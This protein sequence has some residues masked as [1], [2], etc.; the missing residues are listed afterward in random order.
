MRVRSILLT[1]VFGLLVFS[2]SQ[3]EKKDTLFREVSSDKSNITFANKL[4]F[5]DEFNIYTY[6]NYYNGGGAAVG[7]VNNDGLVDIYL[8]ANM[9]GNKLYINKGEFTFEDA[10]EKAGV[11][12]TRAW[13]TGVSMADVNGDGWMDIYV[14]NSG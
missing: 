3:E 7:D 11:A 4:T 2:C 9:L 13:S 1:T 12:G 14:C 10:T 6:R 8:T 5:D